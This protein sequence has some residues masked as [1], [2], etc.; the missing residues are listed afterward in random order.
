LADL[1][2]AGLGWRIP[3]GWRPLKNVFLRDEI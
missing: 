3:E 1:G 2:L